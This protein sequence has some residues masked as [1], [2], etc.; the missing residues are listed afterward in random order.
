MVEEPD[1][2]DYIVASNNPQGEVS[3]FHSDV[4]NLHLAVCET[5]E[6]CDECYVPLAPD[7]DP[8]DLCMYLHS[9]RYTTSFGRFETEMPYWSRSYG[10]V[11]LQ[12]SV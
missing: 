3:V 9:W 4:A 1:Q 2:N 8:E 12:A 5:Q 10:D 7:P 11:P 6:F